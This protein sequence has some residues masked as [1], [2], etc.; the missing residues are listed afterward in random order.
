MLRH[1]PPKQLQRPRPKLLR[2]PDD[3]H[4]YAARGDPPESAWPGRKV[5]ETDVKRACGEPRD[6]FRAGHRLEAH[7]RVWA[8]FYDAREK[9]RRFD[10]GFQWSQVLILGDF[11]AGKT[12]LAA[13]MAYQY[14]RLGHPV[15]SNA[16]LLFGWRLE[17]ERMYTAMGFMPANSVLLI[18]E[19]SAALSSY[20]GGGV[21]V[22]SFVEMNLNTRKRNCKV[23]YMSA[24]DRKI[25]F[26]IRH[27]CT[28]VWLPVSKDK[29]DTSEV[30]VTHTGKRP[31]PHSDRNNFR[32]AW[33]V[34]EGLSVQKGQHHRGQGRRGWVRSA[35]LHEVHRGRERQ[36][37]L[38]AQRHVR[39]GGRRR[40]Q[41][42][43]TPT[44]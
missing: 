28:H 24:M 16:S 18:D 13:L 40:G 37:R 9:R 4:L 30:A 11:G 20:M 22:S 27:D 17:R 21:G 36:E 5:D 26:D 10:R 42:W 35:R 19:S 3:L 44:W 29:I 2:D 31:P 25:A 6:W 43:P 1:R 33:H 7:K 14:F 23:F 12:T 15:F 32:M 39:A 38:S 41:G 34:W 8:E